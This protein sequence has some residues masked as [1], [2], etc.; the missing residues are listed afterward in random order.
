MVDARSPLQTF[1]FQLI[2]RQKQILKLVI[3]ETVV[4]NNIIAELSTKI[5]FGCWIEKVSCP[6]FVD[7]STWM[8]TCIWRMLFTIHVVHAH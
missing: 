7:N 5:I 2:L 3:G 6:K 4:N 8:D 1:K